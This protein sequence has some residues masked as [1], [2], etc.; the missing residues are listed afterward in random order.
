MGIPA[1]LAA[2]V[3]RI[4]WGK[5]ANAALEHGPDFVRKIRKRLQAHSP[6]EAE[7]KVTIEQL[8]ECIRELERAVIKQEEIIE[9]QNRSIELL[10]E[11]GKT[12]Q[13]RLNIFMTISAVTAVLTIILFI[14]LLRK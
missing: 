4:P 2:A 14:L 6:E 12:V 11:I 3:K 9:Q 7:A 8:S 1:V 13:A 10:K 5:V